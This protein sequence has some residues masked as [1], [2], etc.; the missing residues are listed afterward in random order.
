LKHK[1]R[2]EI[3]QW[4]LDVEQAML[5]LRDL[6]EAPPEGFNRSD[7]YDMVHTMEL[8]L[9]VFRRTDSLQR[10]IRQLEHDREGLANRVLVELSQKEDE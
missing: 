6:L 2:A 4:R 8:W 7:A 1:K 9:R 3:D 5:R 10:R